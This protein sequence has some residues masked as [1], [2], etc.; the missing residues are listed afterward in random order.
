MK[1]AVFWDIKAQFVLQRK[2]YISAREPSRLML[3]KIRFF[4]AVIM[5]NAVFRD[6]TPCGSFRNRIRELGA[7]AVTNNRRT[8]HG[9]AS[10]KT[11]LLAANKVLTGL[12]CKTGWNLYSAGDI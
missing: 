3:C 4:T 2:H 11:A 10:Q 8:P 12:S 5:K 1:N 7:L 9:V 6:V